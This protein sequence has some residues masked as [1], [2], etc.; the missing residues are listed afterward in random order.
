MII[1]IHKYKKDN[2]IVSSI[3]SFINWAI[4][5]F[6]FYFNY[7]FIEGNNFLDTIILLMIVMIVISKIIRFKKIYKVFE[8]VND[9]KLKKIED[10]I[11]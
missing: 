1:E 9:S 6:S 8:N 5:L 10:I 4:I 3:N 2:I 7:K 11:K